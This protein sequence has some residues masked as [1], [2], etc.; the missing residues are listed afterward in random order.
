MEN[1]SS[2]PKCPFCS[3]DRLRRRSRPR[4]KRENHLKQRD[5]NKIEGKARG[6]KKKEE[7]L[8]ETSRRR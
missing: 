2:N 8:G 5:H 7:L 6:R 3:C 4:R 1:C